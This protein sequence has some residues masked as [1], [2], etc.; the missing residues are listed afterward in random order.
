MVQNG[1]VF[2]TC[3][4]RATL[5]LKEDRFHLDVS[6]EN[7]RRVREPPSDVVLLAGSVRELVYK[8][9]KMDDAKTATQQRVLVQCHF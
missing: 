7:W 3:L 2:T 1:Y 4:A 9:R 5:T 8:S 6:A